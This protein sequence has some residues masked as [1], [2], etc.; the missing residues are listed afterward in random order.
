ML[1]TLE[2]WHAHS[3]RSRVVGAVRIPLERSRAEVWRPIP[4]T[5]IQRAEEGLVD[6]KHV[7]GLSQHLECTQI[8]LMAPGAKVPMLSKKGPRV[9]TVKSLCTREFAVARGS[10]QAISVSIDTYGLVD[11]HGPKA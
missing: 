10:S 7:E 4:R 11:H 6:S 1:I 3:S 2:P 9:S 8:M 5:S